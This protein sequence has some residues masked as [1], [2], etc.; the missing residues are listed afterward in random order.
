VSATER[1]IRALKGLQERGEIVAIGEEESESGPCRKI[2]SIMAKGRAR[3]RQKMLEHPRESWVI[4]IPLPGFSWQKI[5]S[6]AAG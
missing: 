3:W 2:Y 1:F 5:F 4:S 6:P